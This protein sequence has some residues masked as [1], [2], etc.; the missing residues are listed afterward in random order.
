MCCLFVIGLMLLSF[1]V[2]ILLVLGIFCVGVLVCF[3][4]KEDVRCI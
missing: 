4:N 3:V 1:G 2:S